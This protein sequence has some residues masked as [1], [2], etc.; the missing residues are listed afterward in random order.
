MH[1][2][3]MNEM[4]ECCLELSQAEATTY[5]GWERGERIV[6]K[7]ETLKLWCSVEVAF[8]DLSDAVLVDLQHLRAS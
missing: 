2:S 7:D 6:G 8:V 1:A 5:R 3:H 4:P